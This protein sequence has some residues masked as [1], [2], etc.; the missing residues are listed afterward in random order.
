MSITNASA[1]SGQIGGFGLGGDP[2][3]NNPPEIIGTFDPPDGQVSVIYNYNSSLLFTGFEITG[4][5]INGVLPGGL[6]INN[7]TGVISGTPTINGIFT[8]LSVTCTNAIG[9]STTNDADITIII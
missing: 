4:Y 1:T 5:S 6:T 3:T 2:A 9:S 7:L 8:G